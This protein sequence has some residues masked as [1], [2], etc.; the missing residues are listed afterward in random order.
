[1]ATR[2]R[3]RTS[4]G[5]AGLHFDKRSI[6]KANEGRT[7][8]SSKAEHGEERQQWFVTYGEQ[9]A[10][11]VEKSDGAQDTTSSEWIAPSSL[12]IRPTRLA[13]VVLPV[14]GAPV[15]RKFMLMTFFHRVSERTQYCGTGINRHE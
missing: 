12:N 5:Y 9:R 15:N 10:H 14:P 8:C 6:P 2:E 4:M 1:M 3:T 13:T 11:P 7:F